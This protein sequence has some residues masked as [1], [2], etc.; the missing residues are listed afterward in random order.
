MDQVGRFE[1]ELLRYV[2]AEHES[3]LEAIRTKKDITKDGIEDKMKTMLGE[4]AKSF[5]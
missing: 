4:F 1:A 5:A 3:L 2:H